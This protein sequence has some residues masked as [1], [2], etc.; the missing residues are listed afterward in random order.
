MASHDLQFSVSQ[1]GVEDPNAL[2]DSPGLGPGP[3][4]AA[5]AQS[6]GQL[7]ASSH[8]I[9][10]IFHM[11]FK[12]LALF[13]YIFGGWF[14]GDGSGGTSGANF[15]IV[16]V[17]CILLLA[18]DF[19]VVKNITGRLLVG[20]RWWNK[21]EGDTTRWI[22]ESA[23]DRQTNKFDKSVFWTALYVTPVVWS[24]LFVIGLLK[25]NIGW[26]IIVVMA[27]GLSGANVY[28]YYKC[29]SDQK[30]QFEQ[31][32]QQGAQAG[33]M[34]MFRSTNVSSVLGMLAGTSQQ[35]QQPAQQTY[36]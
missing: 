33:A 34:S 17:S 7:S 20:L 31:M 32:M 16:T 8:P 1:N 12:G 5:A 29:S 35:S 23:K 25:F 24:G 19:W 6:W 27:L 28:G 10:C 15:I 9:V 13:L 26:L 2:H 30:A 36:V 3:Q 4:G 21:V 14:A 18:A 22:F 11:L